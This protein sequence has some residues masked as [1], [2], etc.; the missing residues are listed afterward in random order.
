[1]GGRPTFR[2]KSD[3]SNFM[4]VR[5][6]W[7]IFGSL[8]GSCFGWA[9]SFSACGAPR[10]GLDITDSWVFGVRRSVSAPEGRPWVARGASP[11]EPWPRKGSAPE[12]RQTVAPPGLWLLAGNQGLAPLATHGRPSGAKTE[13]YN[14]IAM[15]RSA[16]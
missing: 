7:L 15:P 8:V 3:A 5:N 10:S 9:D 2:C 1:I 4:T 11:W 13:R 6:S 16:K 14:R 12:G